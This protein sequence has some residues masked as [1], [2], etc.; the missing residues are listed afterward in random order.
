MSREQLAAWLQR[1]IAI[2]S[3]APEQ[4][5][6]LAGEAGE[7]RIAEA[8]AG[9]FS[10]LGGEVH[11]H[12]VLPG[13]PNVYGIWRGESERWLG[14]DVHLDTVGVEQMTVEPFGGALHEGRIYGRGACDTKASLAVALALLEALR[15]RDGRPAANLL[16]AAT[17]DEEI[18]ARGAPAFAAWLGARGMVLDELIVA[19]P[20]EC[21][22]VYGHRG[23]AR[24]ALTV[25]GRAAHSSQPELGRNAI[26]AAAR[27]TLVFDEERR[28]LEAQ[29]ATE[30]G[31]A[32]L[33]VSLIEG[34]SGINVV[35]E[36]CRLGFDRRLL[37]G[38]R[39]E[40]VL[41]ELRALAERSC[42]L[43]IEDETLLALG[44]FLEP[45]G[46]P[47]V[48][49]LAAWSGRAPAL[50]G[51]GTNAWA[52][53][54]V[55]RERVVLGPGSIAQAHSAD[56]WIALAELERLAAIYARW[57]GLEGEPEGATDGKA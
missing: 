47:L 21:G 35:P 45:P 51:Y 9:Y 7:G 37:A 54:A 44:A 32:A 30:L 1:L 23:V 38:E 34:G 16:V 14:L 27:L 50:V 17:V 28:R 41:A 5:G 33:T 2:P 39:P 46:S 18:G 15:A 52:Y 31:R 56:E 29:P 48:Q 43:P 55:A 49:K 20:T 19:E 6:P 13:R 42:P 36:H 12:E 4:A 26:V 57:W 8:V 11:T 40:A 24:M 3:V 25:R 10:A 22:P 53:E